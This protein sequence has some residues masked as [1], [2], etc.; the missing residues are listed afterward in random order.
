M[1]KLTKNEKVTKFIREFQDNWGRDENGGKWDE[2]PASAS[3]F[4]MLLKKA[5]PEVQ[6]KLEGV[7]GLHSM[8]WRTFMAHVIDQ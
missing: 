2:S 4:K 8:E 6:E 1:I 5:L 7:V 3:L